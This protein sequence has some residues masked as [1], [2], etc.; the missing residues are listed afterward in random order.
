[1]TFLSV[2][3]LLRYEL[4]SLLILR[5]CMHAEADWSP[6]QWLYDLKLHLT[7]YELQFKIWLDLKSTLSADCV[8]IKTAHWHC[9]LTCSHSIWQQFVVVKIWISLFFLWTWVSQRNTVLSINSHSLLQ[10]AALEW[11]CLYNWLIFEKKM[12]L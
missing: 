5:H 6:S 9:C 11:D 2:L 7:W 3:M 4:L 8:S 10:W 1:M 12:M